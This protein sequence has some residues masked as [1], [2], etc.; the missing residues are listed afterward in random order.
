M[1]IEA[2]PKAPRTD[3]RKRIL[4][5]AA[6]LFATHGYA[7]T[8]IR[9]LSQ[10]L[11]LTKAALY[12]HFTSKEDILAELIEQPVLA[13]RGVME[14]EWD[15]TSSE[16]RGLFVEAVLRAMSTCDRE[17]VAVFKDP[18]VAPLI[19]Q[20]VAMT[21]VTTQLAVRLAMGLSGVDDPADVEP[22]HLVRA[23]A[24]VGAGYEAANGWRV[25]YPECETFSDMD[26]KAISGYV[27][28][29][30]DAESPDPEVEA[31]S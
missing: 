3:T 2:E 29:V 24:A 15:L 7:G 11:G 16:Q 1:T 6:S 31:R 12:Y 25:V 8:S 21:G 10:E 22:R 27:T 13:I 18:T 20:S 14:Q 17:V 9:D 26:L 5:T 19:D 28:A 30:L 23:I 4:K